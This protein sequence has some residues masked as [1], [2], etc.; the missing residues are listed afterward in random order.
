MAKPLRVLIVEDREADAELLVRELRRG[1]Y[2]V[3]YQRVETAAAMGAALDGQPWDIVLSDFSLPAFSASAALSMARAR[4][5]EIPFIVVSGTIGEEAAVETVRTGA[6]DFLSKARLALL[7][8]AIDRE[9]RDASVREANLSAKAALR[10]SEGRYRRIIETTN[11]GIWML[12]AASRTVFMNPRL[13]AMLGYEVSEVDGMDRLDF[14]HA[15]C[16]DAFVKSLDRR[17]AESAGQAEIRLKR[18]DGSVL[19]VLLDATPVFENGV[20][21]GALAMMVDINDRKRLEEQLRQSQ[22][23]EAIGSLAGGV[24][25]DFNNMLTVIMGYTTLLLGQLKTGDPIRS[26]LEEVQNAAESAANLTR[27]LLAFS[28]RQLLE[29]RIVDLNQIATSMQ[30]MLRRL[31]GDDIELSLLTARQ[32]G[33]VHADPGQIEQIIMNLVVNARDAMP[34]GG[35]VAIETGNVELDADYAALHLEVTPGSYVMLA[36]SDTGVGI[37][38]ATQAR[39]FEPFFTTKDQGKGTGL[40]LST[41]FGIVRQSG[42]HIWVYSEVGTGTTIKI[43]LPRTDAVADRLESIPPPPATLHGSETILLVEDE[44][45]VRGVIKTILRRN[46]YNVLEAENGGEAL[47]I[48]EQ[49]TGKIDLLLT[50][51]MMPRMSGRGLVERVLPIRP[52]MKVLYVSGYTEN[53]IV[54]HG[55][56][57]SGIAFLPKPIMPDPLLRK[58]REV[59]DRTAR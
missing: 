27:Q 50:D 2:A 46:G 26:D 38:A 56:L 8:P 14:V 12:D 6:H 20:Y 5:A 45:Q 37:D 19:W 34:R 23:M 7:L 10:V 51:V 35:K 16:Q 58:V 15:D 41:V 40:G 54:H 21:E 52:K 47:L 18:K 13:Y 22:K 29:P 44:D 49:Y 59:L 3:T 55:V 53:A 1:N 11:E 32:L 4:R 30:K 39:M 25:H 36:V 48:C 24:A 57:D 43:Y 42:G 17:E 31:L 28:R 33:R 9:L